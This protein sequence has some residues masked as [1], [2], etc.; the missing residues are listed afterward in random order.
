MGMAAAPIR[1]RNYLY[2]AIFFLAVGLLMVFNGSQFK[3]TLIG[4][5]PAVLFAGV[6][7]WAY[8]TEKRF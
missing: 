2:A 8:S 3:Y 4:F 6:F 1:P 5:I 7:A